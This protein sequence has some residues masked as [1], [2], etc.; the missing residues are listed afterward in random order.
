MNAIGLSWIFLLLAGA[1]EV[2]TTTVFRYTEGISR[3]LPIVLVVLLGVASFY[4]L[5]RS[6]SGIPL[7]TAYAVWTGIGAAGTAL[8]GVAFYGEP[9][10]TARLVM[11][12]LLVGSIVGLK[13]LS[14]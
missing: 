3:P 8:I 4:F 10:T 6:L 11:L 1:L 7:G 2:A 9:A 12:T 14:N 5:Y 13:L